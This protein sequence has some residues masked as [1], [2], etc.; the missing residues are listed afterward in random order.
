MTDEN[1]DI[2]T[3]DDFDK[4]LVTK[5]SLKEAWNNNP[6]LK[7]VTLVL[8]VAIIVGVYITFFA[9]G[10]EE[11]K[12]MM[13]SE[14]VKDVKQIPGQEE[15]DIAYKK[16]IEEH[17]RKV[18]EEA[19]AKGE[20]AMPIATET[21]KSGGVDVPDLPN[22]SKADP[23]LEWRKATEIRRASLD[24][25]VVD[26][27]SSPLQQQ[28]DVVPMV[29]PIRP[30]A[31]VK[32]D[33]QQAQRLMEQMRVI[34]GAQAPLAS[35]V[36][37]ITTEES[38]YITL[39]KKTKEEEQR[40]KQQ[41]LAMQA[42]TA[43]YNKNAHDAL[44]A[45]K[46]IVPA[47]SIAYAQL[48]TELNSDVQGPALAQVLSGPFAG[49]RMLGKFTRKE[50]FLVLTFEHVIKDGISYTLNGIALDEKTTLAGH[51]TSIDHHYMTRV[52]LPAASKFI[53]GYGKALSTTGTS[54]STT[55][56]GGV[57]QDTPKPDAKESIYKG[58]EEASKKV[59]EMLADGA[60]RPIT[61]ILAKGTTMGV[62]FMESVTTKDAGK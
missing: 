6:L 29:Q 13:L 37:L 61:V 44:D 32:M 1:I 55:S 58:V 53:E 7:I 49:G 25:D 50:E 34:V 5:P 18:A 46:T 8:G 11:T 22:K 62:L 19:L 15:L 54:S 47:G 40:L 9:P 4:G 31:V 43:G 42:G 10:P 17:N 51:A 39:K 33:P 2:D 57:V 20:S 21:T 23:L 59:S 35:Q 27:E 45:G 48:L 41:Q 12:S 60:K 3:P 30:Q 24:S 52:V 28:P 26:D 14:D 16:E 36:L 56:G 38:P